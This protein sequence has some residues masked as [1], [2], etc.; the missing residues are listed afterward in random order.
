MGLLHW[1]GGQ[2][3]DYQFG[4]AAD[5]IDPA[6][7]ISGDQ[8]SAH[9]NP[10]ELDV[11]GRRAAVLRPVALGRDPAGGVFDFF[12]RMRRLAVE[13]IWQVPEFCH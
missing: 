4:E 10:D 3:A 2:A 12:L 6:S 11:S 8:E 7:A 9:S 13:R 1:A 5:L